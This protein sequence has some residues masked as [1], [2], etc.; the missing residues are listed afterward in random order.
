MD[1]PYII[2]F[3]YSEE[4]QLLDELFPGNEFGSPLMGTPYLE[5]SQVLSPFADP[6]GDLSPYQVYAAFADTPPAEN[7]RDIYIAGYLDK[8]SFTQHQQQYQ[9]QQDVKNFNGDQAL[10]ILDKS[11]LPAPTAVVA[12]SKTPS[13][14]IKL[15][16]TTEE[17][18]DSLFPPLLSSQES[19][20]KVYPDC[21]DDRSLDELL[22]Y[23]DSPLS[24][25]MDAE[26]EEQIKEEEV[27]QELEPEPR[28]R[29]ASP[30]EDKITSR[31]SSNKRRNTRKT[32]SPKS[33]KC[34]ICGLESKRKYNL[35][36]HIKTHNKNRVK[37][38]DCN[39]C[40]KSFDR[41]HDRDRHL[42]TVHRHERSFGCTHCQ[43]HFSRGDALNRHL[44]AKHDYDEADFEE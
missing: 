22:G 26:E 4:I 9:Q 5:S 27:K 34:N 36:T 30:C 11:K 20:D 3:T 35:T 10:L 42:S 38:Y 2:P 13:P 6:I 43:A 21:D 18:I 15:Y 44:V 39:Q 1:V 37:E 28:K 32:A 33:F 14:R 8:P 41:R 31:T 25:P 40:T 7:R 17:D 12:E 19:I 29:K 23:T 24:Q 16:A